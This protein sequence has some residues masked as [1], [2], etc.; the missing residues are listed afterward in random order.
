MM[1]LGKRRTRSG[2]R[3]LSTVLLLLA[4]AAG[5]AQAQRPFLV[6]DPFYRDEK[7]GRDF[8]DRF[9][10]TG[11]IAY[12]PAAVGPGD[13]LSAIRPDPF[14]YSLR[15]DYQL[16]EHFD[17]GVIMDAFGSSAGRSLGVSWLALKYYRTV[18]QGDYALRLAIDPASDGQ[19]GFP[20][21]D[22]AFIYSSFLTADV[23][24]DFS[25]GVRRVRVGYERLVPLDPTVPSIPSPI[26]PDYGI[27]YSQALGWEIHG[28]ISY[29]A[30]FDPGGSHI[31]FAILGEA[32]SYE[33]VD[34][35]SD[36]AA[37]E[38]LAADGG[39]TE[40]RGG[41]VWLR[42]GLKFSRPGYA[43][44]PFIG[45]PLQQWAPEDGEWPT[46]R[47]RIGIRLMIR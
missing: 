6:Y 33:M 37:A 26:L 44:T 30:H 35:P 36:S 32:G 29:N 40:Y 7:A 4:A 45:L 16:A 17:I 11:E 34:A 47:L 38:A 1:C 15:F 24:T 22:A 21:L 31:Y 3:R 46:L 23:T 20:Q 41:V 43:F 8:Y 14:G 5:E 10:F 18:D 42:S 27:I 25:L 9:A 2:F 12:V 19:G 28:V 13:G 39:V